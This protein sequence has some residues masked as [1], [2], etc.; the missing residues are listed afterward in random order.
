VS[1]SFRKNNYYPSNAKTPLSSKGVSGFDFS[2]SQRIGIAIL[3][4]E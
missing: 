1:K 3:K 2:S 4:C